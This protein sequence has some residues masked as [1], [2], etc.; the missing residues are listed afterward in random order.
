MLNKLGIEMEKQVESPRR[1]VHIHPEKLS[2]SQWNFLKLLALA[3]RQVLAVNG[4]TFVMA[5]KLEDKGFV[6]TTTAGFKHGG[7]VLMTDKGSLLVQ[8]GLGA[9]P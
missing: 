2:A 8:R 5:K 3:D 4:Q 7:W 6:K 9:N 1:H